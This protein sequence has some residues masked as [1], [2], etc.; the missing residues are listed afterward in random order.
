MHTPILGY[1]E[2]YEN[3]GKD[4]KMVYKNYECFKKI[5]LMK[6]VKILL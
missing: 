6:S 1:A 2:E 3:E 4:I 5:L